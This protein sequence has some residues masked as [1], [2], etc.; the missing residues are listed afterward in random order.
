MNKMDRHMLVTYID[1]FNRVVCWCKR[2]R[3]L[4]P[5]RSPLKLNLGAG[6]DPIDGWINI[7]VSLNVFFAKFPPPFLRYIYRFSGAHNQYSLSQYIDILKQHTF[8]HH[9]LEYGIPFCD[10]SVDYVY[11]HNLLEHLFKNDAERLIREIFRVL[12]KGGGARISVPDL[13]YAVSCYQ[14]DNK[15]ELLSNFPVSR[16]EKYFIPHRYMYDFEMLQAL[17]L[18]AGFSRVKRCK[19]RESN[20]PDINKLDTIPW[21]SLIVEAVK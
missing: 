10:E 12:K 4:K 8:I 2:K 3:K 19:Y 21:E 13:E 9:N 7:D 15:E 5:L 18:K 14:K 6:F 17:L 11:T 16:Q 20:F 1:Y